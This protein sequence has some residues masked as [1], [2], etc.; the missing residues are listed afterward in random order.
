MPRLQTQLQLS[1]DSTL[2]APSVICH[3]VLLPTAASISAPLLHTA[4]A[5]DTP[6]SVLRIALNLLLLRVE[7]SPPQSPVIFFPKTR[8]IIRNVKE[9][10]IITQSACCIP[11]ELSSSAPLFRTKAQ[12]SLGRHIHSCCPPGK[13]F[14]RSKGILRR[15]SLFTKPVV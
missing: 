14:S 15:C 4:D 8:D 11:L 7:L 9:E 10:P 13:K 5:T 12:S 3:L 2:P 6:F 1:A